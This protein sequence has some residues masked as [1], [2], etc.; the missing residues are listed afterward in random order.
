[1]SGRD[2]F[3]SGQITVVDGAGFLTVVHSLIDVLGDF[4]GFGAN[5]SALNTF[6]GTMS[7]GERG[8][9]CTVCPADSATAILSLCVHHIIAH[10]CCVRALLVEHPCCAPDV[11]F[12][13]ASAAGV[14]R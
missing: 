4:V 5:P 1:M 9:F 8:G 2:S 10:Y 14:L 3:I 7:A 13:T 12:D 11:F 6:L